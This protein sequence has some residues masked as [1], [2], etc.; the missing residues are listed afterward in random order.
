RAGWR[1]HNELRVAGPLEELLACARDGDV[2]VVGAR[3]VG[4]VERLLL[5]SVAEGLTARSPVPVLVARCRRVERRARRRTP[6]RPSTPS[7]PS[8]PPGPVVSLPRDRRQRLSTP[9]ACL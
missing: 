3:G 1:V 2:L 9:D 5:G 6:R 8:K 7:N 4:A